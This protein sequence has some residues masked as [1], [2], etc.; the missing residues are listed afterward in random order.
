MHPTVQQVRVEVLGSGQVRVQMVELR[1]AA[2]EARWVWCEFACV[3][4]IHFNL[5]RKCSNV[6]QSAA[7]GD[8]TLLR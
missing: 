8:A 3:S 6:Y 5:L 1:T 2:A 7:C 4:A